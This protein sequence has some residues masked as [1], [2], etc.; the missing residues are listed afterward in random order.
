M[1][2]ILVI[3]TLIFIVLSVTAQELPVSFQRYYSKDGLTSNTIYAIHRDT[4][5]FLWLGTE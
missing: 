5:G 2:R 3:V 1:R 4:Y